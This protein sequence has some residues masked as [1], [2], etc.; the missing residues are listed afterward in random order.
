M[1]INERI[2]LGFSLTEAALPLCIEHVQ[3]KEDISSPSDEK[4][5][6]TD[7]CGYIGTSL[8]KRLCK[9]LKLDIQDTRL[10]PS[11]V[12]IRHFGWFGPSKGV[13]LNVNDTSVCNSDCIVLRESMIKGVVILSM[14][15]INTPSNAPC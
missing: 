3:R 15:P 1:K 8:M 10:Q 9:D 13:L 12:Q 14:Y 5:L 11:A 4:V 6:M 7:G 2:R